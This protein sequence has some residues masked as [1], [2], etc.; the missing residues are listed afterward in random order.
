MCCGMCCTWHLTVLRRAVLCCAVLQVRRS[1]YHE[2]LKLAEAQQ[3]LQIKGE[4]SP[5]NMA[6]HL[7]GC[8]H[9][10]SRMCGSLHDAGVCNI[11][12]CL[13]DV[14]SRVWPV[15]RVLTG[16][17]AVQAG[18]ARKKPR[19]GRLER[20][21]VQW[22]NL[23]LPNWCCQLVDKAGCSSGADICPTLLTAWWLL[24][25]VCALTCGPSLCCFRL[26]VCSR[27]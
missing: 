1:T 26:Q 14:W 25:D 5:H 17:A 6:A 19:G 27:T 7:Q 10:A 15:C 20:D 11:C 9:V 23:L 18:R 2:V 13:S 3:L 8:L 4:R 22:S 21:H 16:Q 12:G 24:E